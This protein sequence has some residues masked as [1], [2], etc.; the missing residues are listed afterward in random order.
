MVMMV[1][2]SS[3]EEETIFEKAKT[4]YGLRNCGTQHNIEHQSLMGS[5]ATFP[6]YLEI[7]VLRKFDIK[8]PR[9]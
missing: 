2:Q 1:E 4:C 3:R 9:S 8:L 6:F 7:E 5:Y